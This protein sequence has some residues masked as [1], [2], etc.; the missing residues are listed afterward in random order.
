M[1]LIK[2]YDEISSVMNVL[3]HFGNVL[4]LTSVI[5]IFHNLEIL[6]AFCY[7]LMVIHFRDV[8]IK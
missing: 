7:E 8:Y 2:L 4:M 3:I 6:N 1:Y 5:Q